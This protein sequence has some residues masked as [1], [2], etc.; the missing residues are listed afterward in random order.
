M[1]FMRTVFLLGL[2]SNKATANVSRSSVIINADKSLT[3]SLCNNP[4]VQ[5]QMLLSKL[6]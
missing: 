3:K 2:H 1:A 5:L 6:F 4:S